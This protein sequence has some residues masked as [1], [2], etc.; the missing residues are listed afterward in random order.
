[1]QLM[2]PLKLEKKSEGELGFNAPGKEPSGSESLSNPWNKNASV[3]PLGKVVAGLQLS[4]DLLRVHALVLGQVLGILP[5]EELFAILC[6]RLATEVAIGSSFLVLGLPESKGQSNS[7]WTAVEGD[8]DDVGD[9]ISSE[10]TLLSAVG[11]NKDREGLRDTNGIGKLHKRPLAQSAADDGFR[12]LSADVC[13]RTVH[14]GWVLAREG[15]ATVCTPATVGV[16]DDLTSSET[17]IT[18]RSTNDPM[19]GRIDVQVCVVTKK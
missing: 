2:H 4:T 7:T 13:C 19:A 5:L 8:L 9:V 6:V 11:L 10:V 14:L 17:C 15:T 12:H 1:M 3:N 18:L 16:D